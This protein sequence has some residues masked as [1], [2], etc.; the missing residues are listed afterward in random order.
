MLIISKNCMKDKMM[1]NQLN[2]NDISYLLPMRS[3]IRYG[4]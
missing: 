3:N 1:N 2:A 4:T